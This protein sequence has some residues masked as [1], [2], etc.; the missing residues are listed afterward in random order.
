MEKY[1]GFEVAWGASINYFRSRSTI[2]IEVLGKVHEA[3]GIRLISTLHFTLKRTGNLNGEFSLKY[4]TVTV[5]GIVWKEMYNSSVLD[6]VNEN[7]LVGP[8]LIKET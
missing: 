2:Y 5:R 7:K 4:S 6:R 3:L 8:N 1:A